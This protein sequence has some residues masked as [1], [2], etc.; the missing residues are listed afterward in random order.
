M[1]IGP[2]ETALGKRRTF[3]VAKLDL[4]GGDMKVATTKI[5]SVNLHTKEPTHPDTG[6]DGGERA[7]AATPTTTGD[8]AVTDPV[9]IKFLEAPAP[10]P[11]NDESFRVVVA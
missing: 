3:V 2:Q 8:T 1:E 5:R 9:S 4:G 11:L 7:A 6:G 10:D